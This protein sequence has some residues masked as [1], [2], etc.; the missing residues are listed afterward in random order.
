P[1]SEPSVYGA[2]ADMWETK[3]VGHASIGRV[4]VGLAGKH[5]ETSR[6]DGAILQCPDEIFITDDVAARH[7]ADNGVRGH[8]GKD[9]CIHDAP[10]AFAR[11]TGNTQKVALLGKR[12]QAGMVLRAVLVAQGEPATVMVMNL[13]AEASRPSRDR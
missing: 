4:Y 10:G 11:R 13:H 7:V 12:C 3:H 9:V 8:A 1:H 2:A 6:R 5:V